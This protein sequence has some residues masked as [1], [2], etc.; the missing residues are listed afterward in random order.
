MTQGPAGVAAAAL[1]V[2]MEGRPARRFA[3]AV[4]RGVPGITGPTEALA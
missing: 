2:V 3:L 1:A 4:S